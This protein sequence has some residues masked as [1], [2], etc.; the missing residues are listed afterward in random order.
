MWSPRRP[1]T[2]S[3]NITPISTPRRSLPPSSR[4]LFRS[5]PR[6]RNTNMLQPTPPQQQHRSTPKKREVRYITPPTPRL[7][8]PAGFNNNT[9]RHVSII[10]GDNPDWMMLPH[11][12]A[13]KPSPRK[14]Y[15]MSD[16][17]AKTVGIAGDCP[18]WMTQ[19]KHIL[20]RKPVGLY[21]H[22]KKATVH[23]RDKGPMSDNRKNMHYF[24]DEDIINSYIPTNNPYRRTK[25]DKMKCK[26]RQRLLNKGYTPEN[27]NGPGLQ[28][29]FRDEIHAMEF[30]SIFGRDTMTPSRRFGFKS[31]RQLVKNGQKKSFGKK[32]FKQHL[33][34]SPNGGVFHYGQGHGVVGGRS[35]EHHGKSVTL[36]QL[37]GSQTKNTHVDSHGRSISGRKFI[38]HGSQIV[39]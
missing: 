37:K 36:W 23:S 2:N 18:E 9:P 25:E 28:S 38:D 32:R 15:T 35:D 5:S 33:R 27:L 30:A 24:P 12:K 31:P 26:Y 20:K 17:A 21:Q 11:V 19:T 16:E 3:N 22:S 29:L 4:H 13:T 7:M 10:Q 14:E 34:S 1:V 39:L 6:Q 8:K